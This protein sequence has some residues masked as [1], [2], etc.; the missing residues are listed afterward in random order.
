MTHRSIQRKSSFAR[1]TSRL[2][3]ILFV[4]TLLASPVLSYAQTA[5]TLTTPA[6]T[7]NEN[8]NTSDFKLIVCDGPDLSALPP[9]TVVTFNGQSVILASSSSTRSANPNGYIPC[10]F[11]GAMIQIQHLINVAMVLGVLGAIAGFSYAGY[12]YITGSK[13]NIDHAKTIFKQVI[14]GFVMMISA[15]FIVYQILSWLGSNVNINT[16]LGKP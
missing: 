7:S 8:P 4:L 13:G 10:N 15:W 14:I 11:N 1:R 16:L 12:L 9:G 5:Q 6:P 2:A 3:G